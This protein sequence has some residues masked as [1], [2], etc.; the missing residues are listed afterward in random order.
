M[1]EKIEKIRR[2]IEEFSPKS[3]AEIEEFR[4]K[5][6]GRKGELTEL[7]EEFKTVAPELKRE[8]GRKMNDIKNFAQDTINRLKTD[9]EAQESD[10]EDK[11]KNAEREAQAVSLI[12]DSPYDADN[13]VDR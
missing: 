4:V 3:Q 12:F 2:C 1:I 10:G 6:L 5:I 8:L 9:F 13:A 11:A 7:F